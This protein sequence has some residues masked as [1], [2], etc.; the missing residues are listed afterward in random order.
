M[1]F[2]GKNF[3]YNLPIISQGRNSILIHQKLNNFIIFILSSFNSRLEHIIIL[4]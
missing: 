3:I 2:L 1:I 4:H